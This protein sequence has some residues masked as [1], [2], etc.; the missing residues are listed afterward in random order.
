MLIR[1]HLGDSWVAQSVEHLTLARVA[2]SQSVRLNPTS[3]LC[4]DGA[5]ARLGFSLSPSL[6]AL[7]RLVF[8]LSLKIRK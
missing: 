7:P 4:A 5:E 8:S 2:I 1:K 3:G 6:S